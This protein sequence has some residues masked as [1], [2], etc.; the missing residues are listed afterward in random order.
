MALHNE[1]FAWELRAVSLSSC[2]I[3][4]ALLCLHLAL[5]MS[6]SVRVSSPLFAL[7]LADISIN[8]AQT[9]HKPVSSALT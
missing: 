8:T 2:C 1:S 6:T 9:Q 4:L 5:A 3:D 7:F